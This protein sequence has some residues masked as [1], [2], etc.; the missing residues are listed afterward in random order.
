MLTKWRVRGRPAVA[1][2]AGVALMSSGSVLVA[3]EA[4]ADPKDFGEIRVCKLVRGFDQPQQKFRIVIRHRG[5]GKISE[6]LLRGGECRTERR[7]AV[8]VYPVREREMPKNCDIVNVRVQGPFERINL[9]NATAV[10]KVQKDRTTTV[11]FVNLCR[12]PKL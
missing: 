1:L 10:V 8:G 6:W 5:E 2:A 7:L 11:T 9:K 12:K 4:A 3:Q